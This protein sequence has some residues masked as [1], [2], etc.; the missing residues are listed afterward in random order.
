M[1]QKVLVQLVD[2]LDGTGVLEQPGSCRDAFTLTGLSIPEDSDCGG[3][4]A[5]PC[6]LVQGWEWHNR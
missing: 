4:D 5:K 3:A 2:D 6:A 1:A